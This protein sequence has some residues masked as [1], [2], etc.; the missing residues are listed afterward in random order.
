MY[1]GSTHLPYRRLCWLL[2]SALLLALLSIGCSAPTAPKPTETEATER[3]LSAGKPDPSYLTAVTLNPGDTLQAIE[4]QHG[5]QVLVWEAGVY[6]VL[7]LES[8]LVEGELESN[9]N[10]F[11]AGGERA[12]MSGRSRSWAR[13]QS[14]S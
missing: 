2:F 1:Q 7:G 6:A 10:A 12:R 3:P 8:E 9:N 11:L 14:R 13:G 4:A 5:G